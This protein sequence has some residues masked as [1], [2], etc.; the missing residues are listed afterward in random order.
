[1]RILIN[2]TD[3]LG[4]TILTMPMAAMLKKAYPDA[5]IAFMISAVSADL[6]KHHR[7]APRCF[8]IKQDNIFS[9]YRQFKTVMQEFNPDIYI[10]VGGSHL[11]SLAAL[12]SGVR[13]RLGLLSRLPSFFLLNKGVRQKRSFVEM[14]EAEYNLNLL[15]PLGLIYDYHDFCSYRPGIRLLDEE[16]QQAKQDFSERLVKANKHFSWD[17]KLIFIHP[18]M[19]GHTLNWPSRNYG[20]LITYLNS[21]C[22]ECFYIISHT[23]SD[24][25]YVNIVRDELED[26]FR[27]SNLF[28]KVYFFNGAELGLRNYM[29]ILSQ[30][31][32]FIG[33]STGTTHLANALGVKTVGLYSPIKVQSALRWKPLYDKNLKIITPDVICGEAQK[34]VLNECP[35]YECMSKIESKEVGQEV[36]KLIGSSDE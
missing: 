31:D 35:Y 12:L 22:E 21:K 6:F 25:D 4:D 27:T 13:K 14:H 33:P 1:M 18:G 20:R 3:A 11:G 30:A 5:E 16:I 10:Y 8:V 23:P 29:A 19:T 32:V 26:S 7:F 24:E 17:K 15:R 34:C 9:T 28:E 36:L 2:R